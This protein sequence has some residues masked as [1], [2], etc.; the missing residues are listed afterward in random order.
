LSE[1]ARDGIAVGGVSVGE[2]KKLIQDIVKHAGSELPENKPRYLMG[3]GTPEDILHAVEHGFDMFDCVL[4]TRL[5]RHGIA[6]SPK[7]NL[8][9]NNA[10]YKT[11]F[12][13][14]VKTCKCFAC[15]HFTKAYIS[16]L[17]RENEMLGGILLSLHNI[18]YLHNLLENRKAKILKK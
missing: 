4:P 14:L 12:T 5:G 11:D 17:I 3:V 9:M 15:T 8:K 1:Y 6:F 10:K 2:E 13:P 16:H 18:A 7:G